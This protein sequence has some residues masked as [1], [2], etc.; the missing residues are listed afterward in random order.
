MNEINRKERRTTKNNYYD[1][2]LL[3]FE[4]TNI[5]QPSTLLI[6]LGFKP[7]I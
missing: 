6:K 1:K 3:D 5:I 2:L 4:R 7:N